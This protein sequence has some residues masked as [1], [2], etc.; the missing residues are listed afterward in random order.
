MIGFLC[1]YALVILVAI[2]TRS[3]DITT[4]ITINGEPYVIESKFIPYEILQEKVYGA[5]IHALQKFPN[6]SIKYM[7]GIPSK[8]EGILHPKQTIEIVDGTKF[9]V[10]VTDNT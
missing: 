8:P 7:N 9:S 5:R 3:K 4:K 10:Y 2:L 1:V 6:C